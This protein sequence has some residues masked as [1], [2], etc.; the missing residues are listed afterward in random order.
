MPDIKIFTDTSSDMPDSIREK[1]DIGMLRFLSVFDGKSY[2]S[3]TEIT[4][5]QFYEMLKAA[6]K[7]PTT[8][9]TPYADMYDALLTAS[10][11]HDSVIYFTISSKGSGQYNTACMVKN[12]ILENDNPD[13][14]IH[15]VDSMKYSLYLTA[16]SIR[17]AEMAALGFSAEDIVEECKK[18][19]ESWDVLLL[20]DNLEYLEKGGRINKAAAVIGSL[21]DIKPVL[22]IR[23]GLIEN[24]DKMRGKKRILEKLADMMIDAPDYDSEQNK[25]M[26]VHSDIEKANEMQEILKDKLG[27]DEAYIVG[28]FGPIVGTHIGPGGIA[29]IYKVRK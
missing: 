5:A 6:D 23:D 11:E 27:I 9:Q 24:V 18:E 22:S 15:I 13:A 1:Y 12:E 26:I 10:R 19:L 17:A 8:A 28:E 21:L 20:V 29:L 7:I 3:G 16:A 2:V 4:N 14:D 25:I